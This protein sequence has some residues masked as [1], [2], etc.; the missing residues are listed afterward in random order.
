MSTASNAP[1]LVELTTEQTA[2][3][4]SPL[5]KP[6]IIRV[7]AE[8]RIWK[9][10]PDLLKLCIYRFPFGWQEHTN[11]V[12]W[13]ANTCHRMSH[14]PRVNELLTEAINDTPVDMSRNRALRHALD[15]NVDFAIF[16]DADMYP[17]YEQSNPE[18]APDALPFFPHALD[19][20]IDHKTPCCVGAPYCSQPPEEMV[21]VMRWRQQETHDPDGQIK[22]DKYTREET[23]GLTGF[24]QVAALPTGLLLIDMRAIREMPPPWFSYQFT[25]PERTKK[26]STEDV[27]FTR[28]LSLCGVPQYVFWNAWA[29]HWKAKLVTKPIGIVYESIPGRI[30]Q[31]VRRRI[32]LEQHLA[33]KKE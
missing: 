32:A 11:C 31:S 13:F 25:D 3:S 10:L 18:L 30:V 12:N 5:L 14:H 28:D 27:V 23:I 22:M 17:D 6:D 4:I 29:G 24:E 16:V 1:P 8:E 33:K 20:A 21:L 7:P 26:A 9:P 19:F 2:E 15:N